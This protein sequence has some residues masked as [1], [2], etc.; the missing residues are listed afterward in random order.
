M[1]NYYTYM[2]LFSKVAKMSIWATGTVRANRK[3]LC[4]EVLIKKGEEKLLQKTPGFSRWASYGSL[5][6]LAWFD[7]R[8]VHLLSYS[9]P[10]GSDDSGQTTVQHHPILIF[11]KHRIEIVR[12]SIPAL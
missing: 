10:P 7:K 1:D 12:E 11:E 9:Y 8:P 4:P 6:L 3:G 5:G 2:P